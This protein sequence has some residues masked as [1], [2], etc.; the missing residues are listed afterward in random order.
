MVGTERLLGPAG[1]VRDPRRP[2]SSPGHTIESY[3]A[4]VAAVHAGRPRDSAITAGTHR[5]PASLSREDEERELVRGN[6]AI[7]ALTGRARPRLIAR[8][9]WD[10]SQHSIGLLLQHGFIYDSSLMGH[11]LICPTRRAD[12]DV[13]ELEAPLTLRPRYRVWWKCRS[14]GRSTTIPAFEFL[15]RQERRHARADERRAGP[16]PNWLADFRYMTD[17]YD[18]GVNHLT[19]SN[20]ARDRPRP[21]HGDGSRA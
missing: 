3:P 16:A 12:G 18:W 21:P 14:A 5:P 15:R 6:A 9:S 7:K 19:R 20:P 4:S 17:R 2:G 11:D 8:P 10:L 1:E 13:A